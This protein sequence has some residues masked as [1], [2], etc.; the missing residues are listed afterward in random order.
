M[1]S[2]NI[3]NGTSLTVFGRPVLL[4]QRAPHNLNSHGFQNDASIGGRLWSCV[5]PRPEGLPCS[6]IFLQPGA[7]DMTFA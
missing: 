1:D 7:R 3:N 5:R 6:G 2:S 4:L